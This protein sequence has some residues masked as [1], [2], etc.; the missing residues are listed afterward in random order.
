MISKA[1]VEAEARTKAT[2][3]NFNIFSTLLQEH[4]EVRLHTRFLHCLLDP[5][6]SHDC[7]SLFLDLFFAT[8]SELH[9]VTDEKPSAGFEVPASAAQWTVRKE[10]SCPPHG[11]I[12]LLLERPGF[13]IAIENKIHA[14]E[15][16]D[17]LAR[18]AAYLR[19]YGDGA[20]V[21]YLTLCGKASSTHGGNPY[22]RISYAEEILT[23]LEKCLQATYHIVP[24]NQVILQ[25]REVVR[26][27]TG[28]TLNAAFM[29]TI[30][31]FVIANPDII[32]YQSQIEAGIAGAR[33]VFMDRLADG[34]MKG[35]GEDYQVRQR[36]D[37]GRVSFG[38]HPTGALIITPPAESALRKEPFQIWVMHIAKWQC[39][40]V[41]IESKLSKQV[42]T[43]P[44][45]EIF[46]RMDQLLNDQADDH[47]KADQTTLWDGTEW[48]TGWHDLIKHP[49]DN[50]RLATLIE[51]F[52]QTV[53]DVCK[54]IREHIA[55]L[56][57]VYQQA[58][59]LPT[60]GSVID[61]TPETD[62]VS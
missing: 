41:G 28:K 60:V 46:R 5:K 21:I 19:K 59:N 18:Y 17:Q 30:T 6:G 42:K 58:K 35:L 34:I 37:M 40:M 24:I 44:S 39:F 23:W 27:L 16:G 4:D 43:D 31:N 48:P 22:L 20:R 11:Q 29:E 12:D 38:S 62:F 52:D 50:R 3:E 54:G 9:P 13:G 53:A 10:A 1:R 2:H 14:Y 57:E 8:L 55:L 49:I 25:Y 7:D 36:P 56:E 33:V 47:H 15:Q 26:R 61:E 51:N 32:R 45:I